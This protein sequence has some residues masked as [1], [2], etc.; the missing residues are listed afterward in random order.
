M[1][2]KPKLLYLRPKIKENTSPFIEDFLFYQREKIQ[3]NFFELILIEDAHI[4]Y[5]NLLK[6]H[7]P[8]MV[9]VI[10]TPMFQEKFTIEN[11]NYQDNTIP[12]IAFMPSDGF[13]TER[14]NL[15]EFH[16]TIFRPHAYFSSETTY[17]GI[18]YKFLSDKI[19]YF[20]WCIDKD[21]FKNYNLEKNNN[22]VILGHNILTYPWRADIFP[23]IEQEYEYY[24]L[25]YPKDGKGIYGADFSKIINQSTFAPTCGGFTD[26][27]VKKHFEIPASYCCL[28]TEKTEATLQAGFV[29]MENCVFADKKNF[30]EKMIFLLQNPQKVAEI[31]QNGYDL[32]MQN[33][34]DQHRTQLLDWYNLFKQ[35]KENECIIQKNLFAKL[36]LAQNTEKHYHQKEN[37]FTRLAEEA[38]M[39]F[40]Q[41]NIQAYKDKY[42]FA[43]H[44]YI[45]YSP[46]ILIHL[47]LADIC[48]GNYVEA[49]KWLKH[50]LEFA[51]RNDFYPNIIEYSLVFLAYILKKNVK[52]KELTP[53]IFVEKI[54]KFV[55]F[56]CIM[57]IWAI[58][59][60]NKKIKNI[61]LY[62]LQRKYENYENTHIFFD[63][64]FDKIKYILEL[65]FQKNNQKKYVKKI[66]KMIENKNI[67]SKIEKGELN[68]NLNI[69]DIVSQIYAIRQIK[70]EKPEPAI[71][72]FFKKIYLVAKKVFKIFF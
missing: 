70:S 1:T 55:W 16:E 64:P 72:K 14:Y 35:K 29:D 37:K 68:N 31:T 52:Y 40:W 33:H 53:F 13:S 41:G 9:F 49:L 11:I 54:G 42:L 69:D 34:T 44:N 67:S 58:K 7:K 2:S 57:L 15:Y 8:D 21:I 32:V 26:A 45:N 19:F 48:L 27:L 65:I 39:L 47:T 3:A 62:F 51:T 60:N 20:P 71:Y 43:Y 56:D 4:N 28:I 36:E 12:R 22:I 18:D 23:I 10:F 66:F 24:R 25:Q 17:G 30:R 46:D 61:C 6:L 5:E 50:P 59:A 38:N 63:L